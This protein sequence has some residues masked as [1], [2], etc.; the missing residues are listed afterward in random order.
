M[1]EKILI[2]LASFVIAII[3]KTGYIG[4]TFLM[5]LESACIPIPSEIILPFSGF[6][7]SQNKFSLLGA[8]FFGS[9]GCLIGSLFAYWIG[10][11]FGRSLIEKYGKFLLISH[12][13]L[14]ISDRF[15]KKYGN[16]AI[17]FSRLLPV[18][19]TFISLPAGI[20]RM[21]LKKFA[22][23]SFFGSVPWCFALVYL[24]KIMGDNW[25]SLEKYFHQFHLLIVALLIFGI[26]WFIKRH[27]NL[28]H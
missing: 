16:S 20:A 27:L 11:Y 5:A 7:V 24:G 23:Y 10:F 19:R 13:D 28:K 18:I 9:L 3:S 15:F 17:F 26:F 22:F 14:E 6:L 2:Y 12:H 25:N 1:F 21:D 4:L 8:T